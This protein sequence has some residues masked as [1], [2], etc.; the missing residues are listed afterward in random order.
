MN[1]MLRNTKTMNYK[2]MQAQPTLLL[3]NQMVRVLS[4]RRWLWNTLLST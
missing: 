3:L 4:T 1:V 2:I